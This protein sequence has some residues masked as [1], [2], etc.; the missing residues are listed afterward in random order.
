[1]GTGWRATQ[2]LHVLFSLS[3]NIDMQI[4]ILKRVD[5]LIAI[6]LAAVIVGGI[7]G[8]YWFRPVPFAGWQAY[9]D[10][11]NKVS[12]MRP[13]TWIISSS[14]GFIDIKSDPNKLG[15]VNILMKTDQADLFVNALG[16][17]AE[18]IQKIKIG[19][20][21][22]VVNHMDV[23]VPGGVGFPTSTMSYSYLYHQFASGRN[24]ILE[25]I[26][27]QKGGL[28]KDLEQ[29]VSTIKILE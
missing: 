25:I 24:M 15:G 14:L 18:N 3:Y 23:T 11:D 5:W 22:W 9:S 28:D 21:D 1:M 10:S 27:T 13:E 8:W 7:L 20:L 26:P 6:A 29:L 4:N 2:S 19:E 12:F 17:D 16:L